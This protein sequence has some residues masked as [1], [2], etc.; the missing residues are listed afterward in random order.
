[1]IY[2]SF[3]LSNPNFNFYNQLLIFFYNLY[4]FQHCN[5]LTNYCNDHP[6]A[7]GLHAV[8]G[9]VTLI[10]LVL[11]S[12][13]KKIRFVYRSETC[14]FGV[15]RNSILNSFIPKTRARNSRETVPI[16]PFIHNYI[17]YIFKRSQTFYSELCYVNLLF[18]LHNM[19]YSILNFTS[20][21]TDFKTG[22]SIDLLHLLSFIT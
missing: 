18:L 7:R 10:F 15:N 12:L 4:E 3:T 14:I 16:I 6:K 17:H 5:N 11:F 20:F 2:S 1:M 19:A 8:P 21:K 22:D 9:S 13:K